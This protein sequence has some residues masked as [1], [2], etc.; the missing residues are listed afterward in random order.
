M[1][2]R[3]SVTQ[4]MTW[5]EFFKENP[6]EPLEVLQK[7]HAEDV[8]WAEHHK[9]LP[10]E[11]AVRIRIKPGRPPKGQE[12]P[13]QVKAVKMPAEFWDSF[14]SQAEAA[15]L[16]LHAAMRSALLEWSSKHRA[17]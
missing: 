12:A 2:K 17:S 16:S 4:E 7:R 5:D 6:G 9:D 15:G 1:T 8:A 11:G 3:K 10:M 14:E 13:V